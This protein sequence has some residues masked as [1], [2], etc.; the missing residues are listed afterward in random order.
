MHNKFFVLSTDG[1]PQAV[2]TG[3]TNLTENGIFGHA[4]VGHIVEDGAIAQAFRDYW[5]RLAADSP[6]TAP[7]RTANEQATPAPPHPWNAVSTAVFS[8]R[9]TEL[10]ALTWYADIAAGAKQALL[11]TFA[12]A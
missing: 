4:D 12:S 2:W 7:Y 11:M 8:P 1:L 5:D 3:S 9:G 6:V 10:D